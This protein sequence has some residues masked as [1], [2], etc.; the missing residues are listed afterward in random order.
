MPSV[1]LE[2]SALLLQVV[3][4]RCSVFWTVQGWRTPRKFNDKARPHSW[5]TGAFH[6]DGPVVQFNQVMHQCQPSPR[7]CIM[8]GKGCIALQKWLE[9]PF[10]DILH[11]PDTIILDADSERTA[12]E[13]WLYLQ[14][15]APAIGSELDCILQ[16]V[17]HN[18]VKAAPIYPQI[19]RC[20]RTDKV[21]HLAPF[22][23]VR[24]QVCDLR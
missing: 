2:R 3:S 22:V 21:E 1:L 24:T 17:A 10:D 19:E 18:L 5:Y 20:W 8:A 9:N 16:Q 23:C 6:R 4:V 13:I 11:N 7:S 15:N 12:H 14:R